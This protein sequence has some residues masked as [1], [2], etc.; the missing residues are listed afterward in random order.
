MIIYVY[1]QNFKIKNVTT[2]SMMHI[3]ACQFC[4][5]DVKYTFE[6]LTASDHCSSPL[7]TTYLYIEWPFKAA[8]TDESTG[9]MAW[10][11]MTV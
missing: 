3:A 8:I 11:T 2:R 6:R 7:N 1:P 5:V 4:Y 9:Q 10:S